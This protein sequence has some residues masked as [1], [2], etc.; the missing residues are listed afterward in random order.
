MRIGLHDHTA[1]KVGDLPE[2]REVYVGD[3]LVKA[4]ERAD[5]THAFLPGRGEGKAFIP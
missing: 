1:R 3:K 4:E 2:V 5:L